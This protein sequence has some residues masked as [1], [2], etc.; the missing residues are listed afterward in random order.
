VSL[1]PKGFLK[2][3]YF[4]NSKDRKF[5]R[6]IQNITGQKPFNI[7]VYKLA[8][9][10]VSVARESVNGIK[11]SNERLEYLGD[12]ILGAI[13]AEFLFKKFP[14]KDEGF[15]TEIRSR[16]VNRE[17]LNSLGKKIG[18]D[19]L[20]AHSGNRSYTNS[21]KSMNGD[22]LEA[23]VG[24]VYL[25]KGFKKCK[26]FVLH[27]LIFPHFDIDEIVNNNRNFKSMLIEWIQKENK[28]IKFDIINEQG[29]THY[30]EF[31]ALILINDEEISTGKG[32]SKK[33][34]EQ[35]A[36]EQACEKLKLL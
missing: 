12:A 32:H 4:F 36:A 15:L 27:R 23:L 5:N 13:V 8:I 2:L 16:I 11:H 20:I 17:S 14:Y 10:H 22:A 34:A 31:T 28:T 33:K 21:H 6:S 1:F 35:S 25:D 24:A 29:F 9:S 19:R 26:R 7:E 30:K 3:F 18:L